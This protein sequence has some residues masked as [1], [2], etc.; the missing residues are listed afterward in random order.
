MIRYIKYMVIMAVV[1]LAAC[2]YEPADE[3]YPERVGQ[4]LWNIT[5]AD[6]GRVNDI[7]DFVAR[8]NYMLS[9]EDAELR[10][11]YIARNFSDAE[12]RVV[13]NRH[14]LLYHTNYGTT[15]SVLIEMEAE[16]WRVTRSG[17]QGYALT[18]TPATNGDY[19]VIFDEL[20]IAESSGRGSLNA[21]VEYGDGGAPELS[22]TGE[23]VMVDAEEGEDTPLTIT[24]NIETA[25]HYTRA[26]G[27]TEGRMRITAHDE[28]YG[29]TDEALV[30]IMKYERT[31]V[32]ESMGMV[33]RYGY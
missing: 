28:L 2:E 26:M 14:Q 33:V 22:Y 7:L 27:M 29:T 8:Y 21:Y 25:I 19:D 16:A 11:A 30:T 20:Y 12:I 17:G 6:L 5:K 1:A 32:I 13:G 4:V 24:T 31:V 9:I 23:L 3:R 15:Y 18:I 10:D